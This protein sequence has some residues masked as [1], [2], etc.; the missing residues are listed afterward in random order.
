M[1]K[2]QKK[3]CPSCGATNSADPSKNYGKCVAC[4]F[5]LSNV[6]PTVV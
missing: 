5:S 3:V 4:N 2:N 6:K 1:Y